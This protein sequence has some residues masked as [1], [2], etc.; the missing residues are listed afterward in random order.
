MITVSVHSLYVCTMC[1]FLSRCTGHFPSQ[2]LLH[3]LHC[4]QLGSSCLIHGIL[5]WCNV[6]HGVIGRLSCVYLSLGNYLQT[7]SKVWIPMSVCLYGGSKVWIVYHLLTEFLFYQPTPRTQGLL[8]GRTGPQGGV[9]SFY[10][11]DVLLVTHPV[12]TQH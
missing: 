2:L 3:R 5:S 1:M 10:S 11:Q 6:L 9:A 4:Q 7:A 8:Q 12:E